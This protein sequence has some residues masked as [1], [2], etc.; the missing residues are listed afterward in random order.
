MRRFILCAI[1]IL[2][3]SAS[4]FV[5]EPIISAEA[6]EQTSDPQGIPRGVVDPNYKVEIW[7]PSKTWNGT[8]VFGN[9]E[10]GEIIEVNM[11][12]EVVWRYEHPQTGAGKPIFTGVMIIPSSNNVLYTV[13]QPENMRGAYE[14]N[15]EGQLVWSFIDKRVSH[16]AQRLPDGNTLINAGHSEDYSPWPYVDPQVFE[17]NPQGEIVWAWH[18]KDWYANDPKYKDVR[19]P[20]H[21]FGLWTHNNK[22]LRLPDGTTLIELTNFNITIIVD[23]SGMPL[24]AF[25]DPC[26]KGCEP[27][28]KVVFPHGAIPLPNGNLLVADPPTGVYELDI[29]K[30]EAVWRWPELQRIRDETPFFRGAQRL[31]NGNTLINDGLGR[32]IEVTRDG[33]KV[34]EL[35]SS[36]Y[37]PPGPLERR[38]EKSFFFEA[39]RLS[40][41]PPTFT[42]DEPKPGRFHASNRIPFVIRE[43]FDV[44]RITY[45][46]RD[47]SANTW[48][49]RNATALENTFTDF[50]SPPTKTK[51]AEFLDLPNGDYTLR[52]MAGSTGFGYKEFWTP[53]R[54][55]YV[56][57]DIAFFVNRPVMKMFEADFEQ[58]RF[59]VGLLSNSTVSNFEFSQPNKQIRFTV[60]G[61]TGTDG[62]AE[63]SIPLGL[64]GGQF[65]VQLDGRNHEFG[66]TSNSTHTMI[67]MD[68]P[69]SAK[70]V[71]IT[72]TVVI[73]EFPLSP[74]VVFTISLILLSI[75]AR[76]GGHNRLKPNILSMALPA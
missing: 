38:A 75:L 44:G 25:G 6:T 36:S 72:G 10:M 50:L 49:I 14:V 62:F 70:T 63:A 55:N 47:N 61:A 3:L 67:R 73:P 1:I 52:V 43:G 35:R 74:L 20:E 15:R 41:M 71:T 46:I 29:S 8:T 13:V 22:A 12:G 21:G 68:Y 16:D 33:Q 9:S 51:G 65:T 28:G 27:F 76:K 7:V 23:K 24:Q 11:F 19:I 53:K 2:L 45:S 5:P 48:I 59:V 39:E 31:P 26:V 54:V 17:L 18:A 64:L 32:L 69:H 60:E 30:N 37:V 66:Q 58:Y 40:Y 4:S 42:V 57:Q 34:W 56:V